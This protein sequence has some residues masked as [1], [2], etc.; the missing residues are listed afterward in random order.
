MLARQSKNGK[1]KDGVYT[2]TKQRET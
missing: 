1:R 2:P